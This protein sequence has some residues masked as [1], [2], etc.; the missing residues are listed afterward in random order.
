[1]LEKVSFNE[2][3]GPGSDGLIAAG[4]DS[5]FLHQIILHHPGTEI[6]KIAGYIT[7]PARLNHDRQLSYARG[8]GALYRYLIGKTCSREIYLY[9]FLFWAN[10]LVGVMIL[11]PNA[12]QV[13]CQR[14]KGFL[15]LDFELFVREQNR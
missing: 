3:I 6:L 4:E 14:L 15:S 12:V 8:Q 2:K 10:A 9:F 7:H 11:R 5:D 13:L 1:M